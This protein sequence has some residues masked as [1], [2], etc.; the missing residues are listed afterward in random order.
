MSDRMDPVPVRRPAA[1]AGVL[2]LLASALALLFWVDP[3]KTHFFP[4][5]PFFVLTGLKCPGCGSARA[6][7][8]MLHGRFAEALG[9]NA[10]LPAMFVLLACCLVFPRH[11]RRSA[12]VWPLLAFIVVWWIVR[13]ATG[14]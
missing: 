4:R 7:H 9:F 13:N 8:A 10:V 14:I 1:R 2:F 6:F 5:C 12:F 11:A 3:S